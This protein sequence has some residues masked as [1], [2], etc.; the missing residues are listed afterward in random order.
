[1]TSLVNPPNYDKWA[2]TPPAELVEV[3]AGMQP[4]VVFVVLLL[5]H[6]PFTPIFVMRNK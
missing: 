4:V 1:M 6:A 5:Y 2:R 3:A